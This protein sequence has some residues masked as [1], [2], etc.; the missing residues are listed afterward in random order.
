[1]FQNTKLYQLAGRIVVTGTNSTSAQAFAF[2]DQNGTL[3]TLFNWTFTQYQNTP[4]IKVSTNATKIIIVGPST[5]QNAN[6]P[7]PKINIFNID[8]KNATFS[9]VTIPQN[10]NVDPQN[11][12]INL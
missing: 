2:V 9:N 7:M 1:M 10:L 5:P 11:V 6:L 12:F 3:N 4:M 8:Y